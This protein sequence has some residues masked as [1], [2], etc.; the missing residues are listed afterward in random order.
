MEEYRSE[1]RRYE[2]TLRT[3]SGCGFRGQLY[4]D[5]AYERLEDA[6]A[7]IPEA[8]LNGRTR[9]QYLPQKGKCLDDGMD[10]RLTGL[11]RV[12]AALVSRHNKM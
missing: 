11:A 3:T 12:G 8:E 1:L 10:G 7:A 4:I 5:A 9:K 6:V 2:S